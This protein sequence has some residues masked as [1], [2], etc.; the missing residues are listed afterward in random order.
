ML[1]EFRR[2]LP[3]FW[4]GI[5]P[6]KRGQAYEMLHYLPIAGDRKMANAG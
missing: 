5:D 1:V 4:F 3:H 6:A 2:D